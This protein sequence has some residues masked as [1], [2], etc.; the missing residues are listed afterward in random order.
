MAGP[1]RREKDNRRAARQEDRQQTNGATPANR[2][3]R[4]YNGKS[5][6]AQQDEGNPGNR[7][8]RQARHAQQP[9]IAQ[10]KAVMNPFHR[11]LQF[12]LATPLFRGFDKRMLSNP[13]RFAR[14]QMPSPGGDG[15]LIAMAIF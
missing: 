3:I 15:G 4:R 6:S 5:A 11:I 13:W 9:E 8:R 14:G 1:A 7:Q 12:I 2:P 10:A